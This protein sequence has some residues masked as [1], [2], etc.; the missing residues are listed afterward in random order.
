MKFIICSKIVLFSLVIFGINHCI[1]QTNTG[2]ILFNMDLNANP[3][4]DFYQFVNGGWLDKTEIPA[5]KTRWGTYD[6]LRQKTNLDA[7]EILKDAVANPKYKSNSDQ[8]KAI[9]LFKTVLDTVGRN[10]QG[11]SP[12]KPYLA[13]INAIK[14]SKDLQVLLSEM[15]AYGGLGFFGI[16]ISADA[17]NSNRNVIYV[18][19]GSVGLPDRDYYVSD[20]A[21]SKE[22]REKYVLHVSKMLQLLGTKPKKAQSDAEKILA[23]ETAMS[24]PRFD[25]VERRDRRKSYN[26]MTVA[27][28]QK[29]T[30]SIDWN[31]YLNAI[32]LKNVDS[33]IVSQPKYMIALETILKENKVEDWKAYMTWTF[34][35]HSASKLSLSVEYADWEFYSKTLTGALKQRP[36]EEIAL[37]II[38]ESVGEALGQLYVEKRFP[39]EAK[40][41]AVKMIKYVFLAFENRINNLPWMT[42][43]TKKTAVEKLHKITPKIG[44][45][46]K[47][48]D[49]SAL[50]INSPEEG[51]TYF[52]NSKNI[53]YWEFQKDIEKLNKPVDKSEWY[54][55]PQIVNAFYSPS[56]NQITFPAGVLQPPFYNYQ[57]DD[58]VNYGSIRCTIGHEVSHAF[59]DSGSRYD[60]EGNLKNWWTDEDLKQFTALT[61]GLADQYSAIEPLPGF[62]IDGKFTLG[63]NIGDLGGVNVSF[64]GLQ[65]HLK[66]N[67]RP[68]LIDGYTPEQRF[69][70]SWTTKW[71]SQIR[72]EAL[73]NQLKT[74]PHS[75]GKYRA[76]VPLQNVDAFYKAFDIKAGDGMYIA[77]EKRVKIW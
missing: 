41:K 15:E 54:V 67:G 16:G 26:P 55:A 19:P 18:S 5:D 47:W 11:L 34:L 4:D 57:A 48:K 17:K 7:L 62:H 51:G 31:T 63:E 76:F 37:Q 71:R 50:V 66:E 29:L 46:D 13:K 65:L 52:E 59:D 53:K 58:A 21:D 38:N 23:I 35:N 72:E 77:P 36:R 10:K 68:D 56:Y 6:E 33:L 74:D 70:I 61:A 24:K 69:Y 43:E 45:P 44:Y 30:P 25:R 22:K 14:N 8:G 28:L 49:Y 1:A 9:N 20:D 27:D 73:K 60:G 39:P 64:D 12:L 2:V 42:A 40:A 3:K 75:P 32:G